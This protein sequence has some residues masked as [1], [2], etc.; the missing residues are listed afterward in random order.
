VNRRA[1]LRAVGPTAVALAGCAAPSP[2]DGRS[3]NTEERTTAS[4]RP[5]DVTPPPDDPILL[6][7]ANG[8]ASATVTVTV[9]RDGTTVFDETV[10]LAADERRELDPGID[11]VGEYELAV[12]VEDGPERSTPLTIESYDVWQGS[13]AI[14][15]LGD[16]AIQVL[17]EE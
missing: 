5:A 4:E 17:V 16:G 3:T 15:E 9:T 14:V 13:N 11:S 1:L 8:D 10:S 12:S 7:L 2:P 6:V